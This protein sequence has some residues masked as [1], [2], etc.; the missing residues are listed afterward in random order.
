LD[1]GIS[2]SFSQLQK[3][4]DKTEKRGNLITDDGKAEEEEGRKVRRFFA[5]TP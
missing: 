2:T 4:W 5:S 1:F 3:R